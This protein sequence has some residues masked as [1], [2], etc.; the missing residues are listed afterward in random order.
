MD[1]WEKFAAL[2]LT[3]EDIERLDIPDPYDF[4]VLVPAFIAPDENGEDVTWYWRNEK[5]EKEW[6]ELILEKANAQ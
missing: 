6:L 4:E 1:L 5:K 3:E 2:E